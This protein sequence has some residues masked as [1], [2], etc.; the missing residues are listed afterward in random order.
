MLDLSG[1]ALL[2]LTGEDRLEW[3]QG[4]ATNDVRSLT[5]GSSLS[6]CLCEPTGQILAVVDAW[7]LP[8]R[9]LLVVEA[10]RAEA[11][12]ERVERMTILEDLTAKRLSDYRGVSIQG[13]GVREAI[14][15][16]LPDGDAGMALGST[17]FLLRSDRLGYGGWDLWLPRDAPLPFELPFLSAEAAEAARILAG[18]PRW[19]G[20]YSSRTL[21]PE[22]GPA[23][24]ARHVSYAKGCYTGQEVLMRMH[25]RGH[26]NRT[27]VGLVAGDPLAIGDE[28]TFE[29]KAVGTVSSASPLAEG[30]W[31]GAATVRNE[32]AA[33]GT[34]L[35]VGGGSAEVRT[36]PMLRPS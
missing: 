13:Q 12:L 33:E 24:E 26:T 28:L 6:F 30:G 31:I 22:L 27:W 18:S 9:L 5:P 36:M 32:A 8:D 23:F 14:G 35:T 29:G 15:L 34:R 16:S 10:S 25:S 11:V 2:A 1:W 3:L 21:P 4:Q 7:A 19:G 20:D 17:A